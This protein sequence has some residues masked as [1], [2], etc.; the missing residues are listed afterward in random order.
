MRL[1]LAQAF[2]KITHT[3]YT[4]PTSSFHKAFH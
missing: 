3:S 1:K 4:W 2:I